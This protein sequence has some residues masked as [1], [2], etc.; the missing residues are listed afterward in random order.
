[1]N[2]HPEPAPLPPEPERI[3]WGILTLVALGGMVAFGIG[4]IWAVSVQEQQAG[5]LVVG[6]GEPPPPYVGEAEI[7]IVDQ[8]PFAIERRFAEHR[9]EKLQRLESYGW[10]DRSRNVIHIPIDR[11]IDLV[12]QEGAR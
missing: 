7:G 10:V 1:M 4:I 9:R 6:A 11:A 12:L 3:P 8:E 5:T 2:H